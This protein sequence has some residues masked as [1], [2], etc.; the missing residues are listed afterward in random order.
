MSWLAIV[1][2]IIGIYLAIKVVGFVFKL[3]LIVLVIAALYWLV[4]P[5]L[6]APPPF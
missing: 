1:I 2:M 3:A 6:G 5:Y 4:S